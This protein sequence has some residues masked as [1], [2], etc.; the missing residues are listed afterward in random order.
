MN[1]FYEQGRGRSFKPA[2]I[3]A[4]MVYAVQ[5]EKG[6]WLRGMV[7]NDVSPNSCLVQLVDSGIRLTVDAACIR[8]LDDNFCTFPMQTIQMS[9]GRFQLC[10]E[11]KK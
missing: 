9:L 5:V 8:I 4:E 7:V 6:K 1:Y 3:I 10:S 2:Q 11:L